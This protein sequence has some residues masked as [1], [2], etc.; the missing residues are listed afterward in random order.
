MP[1]AAT[2]RGLQAQLLR[3]LLGPC[4]AAVGAATIYTATDVFQL[5]FRLGGIGLG[6]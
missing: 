6:R 3:G 1:T 2:Q 5:R 4:R